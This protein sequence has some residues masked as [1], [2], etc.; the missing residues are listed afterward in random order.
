MIAVIGV[1]RQP[2]AEGLYVLGDDGIVHHRAG[3]AQLCHDATSELRLLASVQH[4]VRGRTEIGQ[5]RR[6]RRRVGAGRQYRSRQYINE[7][8]PPCCRGEYAR[9]SRYRFHAPPRVRVGPGRGTLHR[10]QRVQS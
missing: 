6:L 4:G 10:L 7:A 9:P 2:G 8:S 3:A 1:T 5:V